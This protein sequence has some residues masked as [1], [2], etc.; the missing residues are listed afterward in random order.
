MS[1]SHKSQWLDLHVLPSYKHTN[2]MCP[3]HAPNQCFPSAPKF[4]MRCAPHRSL[5]SPREHSKG[6]CC[7][8]AVT[9]ITLP[10]P[11]AL[12]KGGNEIDLARIHTSCAHSGASLCCYRCCLISWD[13][14]HGIC[15]STAEVL[16]NPSA[17]A[18]PSPR[19]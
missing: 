14:E 18:T 4:R 11:V 13:W 6:L 12:R 17:S 16:D 7:L 10:T 15:E 2:N 1:V 3:A 8:L 19:L 9:P 5:R